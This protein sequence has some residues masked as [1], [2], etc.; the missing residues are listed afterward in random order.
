MATLTKTQ[1]LEA[2]DFMLLCRRFEE[3]AA[4]L[5]Q[6][7]LMGGFLHLYIGQEAVIAGCKWAAKDG[8]DYITSYRCH[9]HALACGVP[10]E[11]IM[12]ELTGRATGLSKGKG[13][14]MHLFDPEKRFWGGHGIVAAQ[15]PLGAGLAFAAKYKGEDRVSLTFL[16]DGAANAGQ[17]FE[18]LNMAALWGLPALFIIENNRYSMGTA[19]NRGSAGDLYKRGECFGIIGEKVDGQDLF[20]VYAA[21]SKAMAYIRTHSKPYILEMDTYRYRGHSMSDPSKYRSRDEVENVRES[22]DPITRLRAALVEDYGVKAA[23]L[24]KMDEAVKE[25]VNAVAEAATIAPLPDMA[26]LFTDVVPV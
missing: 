23:D 3:K 13:G 24:E 7:G 6:Q 4:A 2:Y 26:Q 12:A 14:S 5:Y 1:L 17:F 9:A 18:T 22:R 20:A 16:G 10:P 15:V 11:A 21:V 19:V 25:R 8:D